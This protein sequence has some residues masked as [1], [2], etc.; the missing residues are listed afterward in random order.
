MVLLDVVFALLCAI[1]ERF[2][3]AIEGVRSL[4]GVE[5]L[6]RRRS[7]VDP[8]ARCRQVQLSRV[9]LR[10]RPRKTLTA[11][12]LFFDKQAFAPTSS[13]MWQE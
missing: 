1:P 13:T 10:E 7:A 11:Q 4:C 9:V 6:S 8:T 12:L 3:Q 2:P 5:R